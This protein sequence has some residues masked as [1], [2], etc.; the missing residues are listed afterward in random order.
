MVLQQAPQV[1]GLDSGPLFCHPGGRK[2]KVGALA[3]LVPSAAT[4]QDRLRASPSPRRR[5]A[6]LGGRPVCSRHRPS[7]CTLL[8][9]YSF[10]K[11]PVVGLGPTLLRGHLVPASYTCSERPH[12]QIRSRAGGLAPS[13]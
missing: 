10:V 11:T 1:G 13:V 2:S 5:L 8:A 7:V 6:R 3:G 4:R 12:L 9:C